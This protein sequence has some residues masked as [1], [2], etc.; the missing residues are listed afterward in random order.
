MD[1]ALLAELKAKASAVD[2]PSRLVTIQARDLLSLLKLA[3][4][5]ADYAY[6]PEGWE[7]TY[8]VADLDALADEFELSP[9]EVRKAETLVKALPIWAAMVVLSRDEFGQPDE[10]DLKWFDTEADAMAA[11]AGATP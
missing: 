11:V 3:D 7:T 5:T 4:R 6:N 2:H 9:G 8:S 10:T 1:A